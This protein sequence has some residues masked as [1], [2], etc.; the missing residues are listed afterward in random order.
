MRAVFQMLAQQDRRVEFTGGLEALAL[1]DYQVGLLADLKPRPNC[2]FAY[3]PGD[4]FETL[5]SAAG[6]L[7]RGRIHC[8]IQSTPVLR[9]D[10]LSEGHI[11]CRGGAA[12]QH[13]K[14]ASR[15]TRCS[16]NQRRHQRKSIVQL[17]NGGDFNGLGQG[18]QSY[19]QRPNRDERHPPAAGPQATTRKADD[20]DQQT[21]SSGDG[22]LRRHLPG[23]GGAA[24][25]SLVLRLKGV[26]GSAV[27]LDYAWLRRMGKVRRG[28]SS[29]LPSSGSTSL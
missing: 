28:G 21:G 23:R 10:R 6:S 26:Q 15:R 13:G 29:R 25:K 2:F 14:E 17:R 24:P 22:R 20:E 16:G 19:T 3:D 9:S 5:K 4:P 8:R 12:A 11:R 1:Q 27:E 18:R 7:A